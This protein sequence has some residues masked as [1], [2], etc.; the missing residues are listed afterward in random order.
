MTWHLMGPSNFIT[1]YVGMKTVRFESQKY[2]F[3]D[4]IIYFTQVFPFSPQIKLNS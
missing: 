2:T 4:E 3:S 1:R